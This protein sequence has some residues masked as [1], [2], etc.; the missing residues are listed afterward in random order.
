M[1]LPLLKYEVL[2][3]VLDTAISGLGM[4]MDTI[5]VVLLIM[6]LS[7]CSVWKRCSFFRAYSYTSQAISLSNRHVRCQCRGAVCPYVCIYGSF[8]HYTLPTDTLQ[9]FVRKLL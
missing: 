6:L 8:V 5:Q 2:C 3:R 7:F 1:F 9:D 4:F